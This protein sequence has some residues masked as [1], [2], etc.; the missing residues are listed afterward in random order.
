MIDYSRPV[1]YASEC[2]CALGC[3]ECEDCEEL[4]C[5][6]CDGLY[7]EC[8]C[9]G[10]NNEPCDDGKHVWDEEDRICFECDARMPDDYK[11]PE[12]LC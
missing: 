2:K 8:L 3:N 6:Q 1:V 7:A 5:P 4:Q 10:P 11:A 12:P 9:P